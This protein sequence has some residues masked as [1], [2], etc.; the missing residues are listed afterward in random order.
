M[1]KVKMI[2]S[3]ET[4]GLGRGNATPVAEFNVFLDVPA[5]KIMI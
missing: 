1:N 2:W 5:Y 4:T 3:M